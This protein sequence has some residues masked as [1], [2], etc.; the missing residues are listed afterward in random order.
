MK[1]MV[2]SQSR[3]CFLDAVCCILSSCA[4]R[5]LGRFCYSP[6]CWRHIH[7]F[8]CWVVKRVSLMTTFSHCE[9]VYWGEL[10]YWESTSVYPPMHLPR[11]VRSCS[12]LI[13]IT[14]WVTL[15]PS[16]L[17]CGHTTCCYQTSVRTSWLM[18]DWYVSPSDYIQIETLYTFMQLWIHLTNI[19]I[20]RRLH[21]T[22]FTQLH[23]NSFNYFSFFLFLFRNRYP[24]RSTSRLE[25]LLFCHTTSRYSAQVLSA[26]ST[27]HRY[28][29]RF[30]A[31]LVPMFFLSLWCPFVRLVIARSTHELTRHPHTHNTHHPST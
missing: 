21:L 16:W 23:S 14:N 28:A 27:T 12:S 13:E 5:V 20:E 15:R 6:M 3:W 29:V 22:Q 17:F 10:V 11:H 4:C 7:R 24:V 30:R 31:F 8:L 26:A 19:Q 1:L 9:L 2:W 18:G 25:C